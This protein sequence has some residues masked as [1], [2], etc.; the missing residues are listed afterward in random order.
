[1]LGQRP[2]KS[3][4]RLNM[5][6]R[7]WIEWKSCFSTGNR[8]IREKCLATLHIIWVSCFFASARHIW[9]DM[10]CPLTTTFAAIDAWSRRSGNRAALRAELIL[11]RLITNYQQTNNRFLRPDVI[12]YTGVMKAY[13]HHPKGGDKALQILEEMND[14]YR[15]G[16]VKAGPD[17]KSLSV[18]MD[19]C[20]KCGLTRDAER[21]LNGIEDSEKGRVLFNIIMSGYKSEGRGE[22]AEAALRRMI[23]LEKAG[24]HRCSP[25]M[26]SYALCIEA[27]ENDKCQDRALRARAL[28]DESIIRYQSGDGKCKPSNVTFN[29]AAASIASS[30]DPDREAHVL[31]LFEKME[32]IGC[33]PNLISFNIL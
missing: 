15:N 23:S 20:V 4:K 2:T 10:V 16:N 12:S 3:T 13:V 1:M 25:D 27:W 8:P 24:R 30:D 29:V 26:I 22:E 33:E 7:S 11:R 31:A 5:Q 6:S 28:L 32:E 17:R 14:Q 21:I 19:A 18:A 9:Y